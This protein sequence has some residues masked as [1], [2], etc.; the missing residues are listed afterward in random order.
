MRA[1]I[2][3][4]TKDEG[5]QYQ[6]TSQTNLH[7]LRCGGANALALS[8]YSDTQIQKMGRWRGATFK[9]Y[10][11][12]LLACYSEG[13]TTKMKRNFKFVNVHGNAYHDVTSTCVL[14][15]YDCE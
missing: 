11:R 12:E 4:Y 14:S 2:Q 5:T 9:E 6:L 8:G 15:D 3:G 1:K 13:M 7:S 10:I